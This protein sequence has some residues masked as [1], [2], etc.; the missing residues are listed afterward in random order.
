MASASIIQQDNH[1]GLSLPH[2]LESPREGCTILRHEPRYG[3]MTILVCHE[4]TS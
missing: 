2:R 4:L 3:S 1:R